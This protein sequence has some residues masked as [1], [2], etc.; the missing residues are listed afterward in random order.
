MPTRVL[1]NQ[2]NQTVY[3]L[4]VTLMNGEPPMPSIW[5]RIQVTSDTRLPKLHRI[6]QVVMG[7]EDYHLHQFIVGATPETLGTDRSCYGIPD[8]DFE[9]KTI[10]E[11]AVQLSRLVALATG[12]G[13]GGGEANKVG[14]F[15]EPARFMYEYDFGDGWQHEIVV[16]ATLPE[17]EGVEYPICLGG[18]G[19]CPLEDVGGIGGYVEFLDATA[20]P[21][22]P[23]HDM[24]MRWAGGSFDPQGFDLDAVNQKL[25]R[26]R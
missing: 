7:W 15:N 16:E 22:N 20:N 26:L 23:E 17:Q 25:R 24:M 19:A 12:A 3:Q 11:R 1:S 10:N 21:R 13:G 18:E 5:R 6:L 8:P 9:D 4:K 2:A 14:K